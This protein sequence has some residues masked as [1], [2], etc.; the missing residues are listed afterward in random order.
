MA[1]ERD[2]IDELIEFQDNWNS[3]RTTGMRFRTR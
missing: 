1:E 2:F 3:S